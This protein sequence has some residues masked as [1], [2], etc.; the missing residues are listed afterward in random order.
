[1]N[2]TKQEFACHYFSSDTPSLFVT[3]FGYGKLYSEKK[4]GPYAR[5]VY[6]L[7]FV[8][9]GTCHF[10]GFDVPAGNAFL[11][12]KKKLHSFIVNDGYE[13]YWI[14][15]D[16]E[17]CEGLFKSFGLPTKEHS[18]LYVNDIAYF[19][20]LLIDAFTYVH[21]HSKDLGEKRTLSTLLS[22]L[23][24]LITKEITETSI[25][26][27]TYAETAA[28]FIQQNFHR[29][30]KIEQVAQQV[31]ISEK[32]LY[33][34]FLKRFL[35]S[36]QKYLQYIRMEEAKHLV[37][38]TNLLVKEISIS[39]GYSTQSAFSAA[40]YDYYGISP[41]KMRATRNLNIND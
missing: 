20:N 10:Q 17:L 21:T 9:N 2:K 37:M 36:P 22:M 5:S 34:L 14:A 38:E 4:V 28:K 12:S 33:R 25:T 40:F 15:F 27:P 23:P 29:N 8:V 6:L 35:M 39:V 13:H 1:M 30:I 7:H 32:Y 41:L 11:I 26:V 24:M 31:N 18:L 16:G 3:E 19:T